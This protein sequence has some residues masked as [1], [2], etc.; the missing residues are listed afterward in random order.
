MKS[1]RR[2]EMSVIASSLITA[3][4]RAHGITCRTLRDRAGPGPRGQPSGGLRRQAFIFGR[5]G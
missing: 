4:N 3:G 5:G 2:M 1:A